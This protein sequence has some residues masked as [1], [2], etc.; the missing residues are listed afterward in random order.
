MIITNSYKNT[1]NENKHI[2]AITKTN[3][4]EF[5]RRQENKNSIQR[6]E[7]NRKKLPIIK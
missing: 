7:R 3:T 5:T 2:R 4:Y 1:L 6:I